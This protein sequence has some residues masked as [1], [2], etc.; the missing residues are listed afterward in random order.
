L[1]CRYRPQS[2]VSPAIYPEKL[3][4]ASE[5]PAS[6]TY[7]DDMFSPRACIDGTS[8]PPWHDRGKDAPATAAVSAQAQGIWPAACMADQAQLSGPHDQRR[9]NQLISAAD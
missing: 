3:S 9:W 4:A 2:G 1:A 8:G 5:V 7:S 6:I